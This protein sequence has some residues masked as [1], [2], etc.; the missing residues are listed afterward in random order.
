MA[1]VWHLNGI[2]EVDETEEPDT[3]AKEYEPPHRESDLKVVNL[4][5]MPAIVQ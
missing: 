2:V 4:Y 5:H 3:N 1:R